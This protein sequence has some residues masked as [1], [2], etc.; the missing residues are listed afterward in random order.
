MHPH[1]LHLDSDTPLSSSD[2]IFS[3]GCF[4]GMKFTLSLNLFHPF[5]NINAA[6]KRCQN[7]TFKAFC[8]ILLPSL[9]FWAYYIL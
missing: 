5:G 2:F 3:R 4:A 9:K 6:G 8:F 7:D 1:C